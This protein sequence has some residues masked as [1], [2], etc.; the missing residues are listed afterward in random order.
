MV[1]RKEERVLA[2]RRC[3]LSKYSVNRKG[4]NLA[5]ANDIGFNSSR[6]LSETTDADLRKH[7]MAFLSPSNL[8]VVPPLGRG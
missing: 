7:F 6:S 1:M 4:W 3:A 5:H 2:P 8:F